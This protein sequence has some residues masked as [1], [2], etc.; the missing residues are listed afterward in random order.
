[1]MNK[2]IKNLIIAFSCLIAVLTAA[3]SVLALDTGLSYGEQIGLGNEDPRI[4]IANIIRVALGFLGILAVAIIIYG[5][6]LWMTAGGEEEKIRKAKKVLINAAIGLAIIL[7]SFLIVSFIISKLLAATGAGSGGNTCEPP[8]SGLTPNCC[9]GVCQANAC[10]IGAT[11]ANSFYI[12]RTSP[13]NNTTDNP[14]NSVAI[15]FYNKQIKNDISQTELSNNFKVEKIA[16]IDPTTKAET[17][18]SPFNLISGTVATS[19][20]WQEINFRASAGCGDER[21]TLNCLPEWSKFKVTINASSQIL[22]QSGNQSLTCSSNSCQF[23]FATSDVIDTG[24]PTAGIM[25]TQICKDDNTLKSDANTIGGWGKDDV[26]VSALKFYE[27]KTGEGENL[28]ETKTGNGQKYLYEQSKYNTSN[29]AVGDEYTFKVEAL[30]MAAATATAQF[31]TTIKP[32]HCCNGRRDGD[33]EDIDCGGADCLAC[34]GGPCNINEPNQCAINSSSNCSDSLCSTMFCDCQSNDCICKQKPIID[35]VSPQGGFCENNKDKFCLKDSDCSSG[36]CNKITANGAAGNFITIGGRYFGNTAGTVSFK[37]DDG[38]WVRAKLANDSTDGNVACGNNVWQTNQIIAIVPT[39]LNVNNSE[40]KVESYDNYSDTTKDSRGRDIDFIVNSIDRPG[41]CLLNPTSGKMNDDITYNGIKMQGGAAYF[42]SLSEKIAGYNSTF[43]SDKAGA[44]EVPNLATGLTS[45]FVI[46]NNVNSNFLNFTKNAEPYLG[47]EIISFE[48]AQGRAGQYV[49]IRGKRFGNIKGASAVSFG[50]TDGNTE[51][52]YEFPKIC[53]DNVWSDNQII[54]KVPEGVNNGDYKLKIRIGSWPTVESPAD[55]KVDSNLSL[56]PSLCK[57]SPTMGPK[58]SEVSLWGEYFGEDTGG[59]VRFYLDKDQAEGAISFWELDTSVTDGLKPDKAKTTVH[60][61]ALT[62]PVKIVQGTEEGNGMNFKVGSCAKNDECGSGFF[63]CGEASPNK[64]RCLAGASEQ[65]AC[66]PRVNSCVYEWDF[67]T[68]YNLADVPCDSDL[69][70]PGCQ[71]DNNNRCPASAPIC[72]TTTCLCEGTNNNNYGGSTCSGYDSSQCLNTG[73]CPNSP[74]QCSVGKI[75]NAGSCDC[76][77]LFGSACAGNS[78]AYNSDNNACQKNSVSCSIYENE[79]GAKIESFDVPSGYAPICQAVGATKRW[80]VERRGGASCPDYTFMDSNRK[81]TLGAPANYATCDLC[82]N[83]FYCAKD[84]AADNQGICLIGNNLCPNSASCSSGQCSFRTPPSTCECC[85]RININNA[86]QDCCAPLTCEGDCG[87]DA[88]GPDQNTYGFCSGCANAGITQAERNAACNCSGSNGKYC[89][90]TSKHPEG[91]CQDCAQINSAEQC[92][93]AGV[94]ECCVDNK[95]NNACSGGAGDKN[96][97]TTDT[98]D[99]AYCPYYSCG[100]NSAA[101][102][103]AS[104]T[105]MYK[106]NNCDNKCSLGQGAG[107]SCAGNNMDPNAQTCNTD[108]CFFSCLNDNGG[109]PTPPSNCGTCCCDPTSNPDKCAEINPKLACLADK[110]ACTGTSRGLCC[111]CTVN[112]DCGNSTAVGCGI[113]SCCY[114]RPEIES[115]VPSEN[116]TDVCRNTIISAKFNQEMD[117]ASFSG[118]VYVF[119]DYGVKSCPAGTEYLTFKKEYQGPWAVRWADRIIDFLAGIPL[120]KKLFPQSANALIGNFCAIKGTVSGYNGADDKTV[121]TFAPSQLLDAGRK[122][123]VLIKGDSNP[124]DNTKE[125]VLSYYGISMNGPNGETFNAREFKNSKIWSFITLSVQ[126]ANNGVCALDH[127]NINPASYLFQ[128]VVNNPGDDNFNDQLKF[129]SIEDS[130]KIFSA[131]GVAADGQIIASVPSYAWDWSW[132]SSQTSVADFIDISN[133]EANKKFLRAKSNI[134][135]GKTIIT[136][137][138]TISADQVFNP[139]T[140]DQFKEAKA[141][142]WVF[143]C[144]NPWPAVEDDGTWSPWQDNS[145]NCLSGSGACYNTNYA[146]YYCRDAGGAGT[147]DDLPAILSGKTVIRGESA[148]RNLLK[149]SYFFREVIPDISGLNLEIASIPA[150]GKKVSL[151]WDT[152]TPPSGETF[153]KYIIYYGA[154]PKNYTEKATSINNSIVIENLKNNTNYYFSVTAK[155]KSGAESVYSAEVSATPKDAQAPA[156]PT[157]FQLAAGNNQVTL[158]WNANTDDTVKYKVFYG[159]THGVYGKVIDVGKDTSATITNLSSD[160]AFYYFTVA[161]FDAYENKSLDA[162]EL[163][164]LIGANAKI[165]KNSLINVDFENG[166][167]GSV[168]SGWS[169]STQKH[170]SVGISDA[171]AISGAKSILIHQDANLAYPGK[172][173]KAICDDLD[174][175]TMAPCAWLEISKQCSF[176]RKD[177][178]HQSAPAVYNENANLTCENNKNKVMWASLKYNVAPLQWVVDRDYIIAFFYKGYL[179][180]SSTISLSYASGWPGQSTPKA[181]PYLKPD[182]SCLYGSDCSG[183]ANTCCAQAPRQ[184]KPYNSLNFSSISPGD[185][186]NGPYNGWNLYLATFQYTEELS[187]L[188]DK[189]GNLHNEVAITVDYISTG[190]TA[191]DLYIDNFIV[192]EKIN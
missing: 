112:S 161:A 180:S 59:K 13:G 75:T 63:C 151:S 12:T 141:D 77:Y 24:P 150:E 36:A 53:A 125:G 117:S 177:T 129:D 79:S 88:V 123:Y 8:C 43:N 93:T 97:I 173:T 152:I 86:N 108:T 162:D 9:N 135:E 5:G 48:P 10:G 67:S 104:T 57:I 81:C 146:I 119:G 154:S 127:V 44:A 100:S 145:T 101:C 110:G 32:G 169:T 124:S 188:K 181:A 61:E 185:H 82:S 106:T 128:T 174:A 15:T 132:T 168:P 17:A 159:T 130:D 25:P 92:T 172:C 137:R 126:A 23:E 187:E 80:Q 148:A 83:G 38:N 68:G 178:C 122:Y 111:G 156:K 11:A 76:N 113:D 165:F 167:I 192:A 3:H 102:G 35:W 190:A 65:E 91:I 179:N 22:A 2:K 64:G 30:D 73:V 142:A 147:A 134:K 71:T 176:S 34:A 69:S 121:L 45:S 107:L 186:N 103:S 39:G 27:Q 14:R 191:T 74:G 87:S 58:L 62:G 164:A 47:P 51:A 133:L 139:S 163:I 29:M 160:N 70:T 90:I 138:A 40:I 182:N 20:N 98:P 171:K 60:L 89:S 56:K 33:E 183:Q 52:S 109:L 170:S 84:G 155:F 143:V 78:C 6:W 136:A 28:K 115:V 42:G 131:E 153:D 85:C 105:G 1:M 144:A 7:S 37:K 49:T 54:V 158:N 19:S 46:K 66:Y 31:K 149:E 26:G 95:N 18:L 184:T 166:N 41:L 4:I 175:S 140:I 157:G 114:A 189:D 94:G 21:N 72:N 118:N 55:F 16:D 50:N 99:L 116:K 120:I 96:I